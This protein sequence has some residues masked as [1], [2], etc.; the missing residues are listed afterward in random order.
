MVQ[1]NWQVYDCNGIYIHRDKFVLTVGSVQYIRS[2]YV[3]DIVARMALHGQV[4][5]KFG[6]LYN[7]FSCYQTHRDKTYLSKKFSDDIKR[8][9]LIDLSLTLT[10]RYWYGIIL[11]ANILG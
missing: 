11:F 1:K 5:S 3:N 4:S 7:E 10:V 6:V 8:L 9:S 2:R